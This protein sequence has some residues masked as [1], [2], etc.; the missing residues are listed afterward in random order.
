ML[1]VMK[2]GL[3][4]VLVSGVGFMLDFTVYFF[5]TNF[6]EIK[7]SYANMISAIPAVTYVF[8]MSTRKIFS[9]KKSQISIGYKYLIYFIYQIIL[10]TLV[11]MFAQI[12]Y[13]KFYEFVTRW[14]IIEYNFKI[15]IKCFITPITM[16]CNFFAMKILCE[17][18]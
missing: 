2:Q 10:V 11:S 4:F 6:I 16:I 9:N 12:L 15:I 5:I 13:D 14:T 7:L 17:K 8:F 1:K 18:I 3:S